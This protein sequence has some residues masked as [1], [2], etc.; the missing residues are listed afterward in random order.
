MQRPDSLMALDELHEIAP[1]DGTISYWLLWY[2]FGQ[3]VTYA[4]AEEVFRPV[5]E[6]SARQIRSLASYATND[7]TRFEEVMNRYAKL[8]P[9]GYFEL[10]HFFTAKQDEAKAAA[11]FEKGVELGTDAVSMANNCDWLVKYYFRNGKLA[12]AESLADRAAEVYS[13]QGL[14][15]KAELLELEEKYDEA[16]DYYMKIEERYDRGG[17][18]VGFCVRYKAKTG[19]TRF[20]GLVEKRLKTLFPRGIEKVGLQDFK[21]PPELGVLIAE[22]NELLRQA[23]LKAGNVIVALDGIRVYD[24]TQYQYIRELTKDLEIKFLVWNGAQYSEV[25]ASPP[26][27]RFGVAFTDFRRPKSK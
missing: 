23:S 11:Y 25:K 21:S 24:M 17:P 14:E 27:R 18:V 20:D 2:R 5:L 22:E 4:Q 13:C 19:V 10:G 16:L 7:S 15:T 9:Y 12:Q 8:N 26:N 3:R 1:Y 6:Y